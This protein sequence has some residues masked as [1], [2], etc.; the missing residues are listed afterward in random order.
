MFVPSIFAPIVSGSYEFYRVTSPAVVGAP[1]LILSSSTGR[2][3]ASITNHS[4]VTMYIAPWTS[5][6]GSV[7]G[8]FWVKLTSGSYFELPTPVYTGPIYA[9][10][11]G[12]GGVTMVVD[13]KS[14]E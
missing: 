6:T 2:R 4:N 13:F 9:A 11:D 8:G 12:Q 5:V 7:A 14:E 10:W 1:V 3:A